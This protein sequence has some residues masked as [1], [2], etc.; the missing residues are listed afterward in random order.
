M[1]NRG[2]ALRRLLQHAAAHRT[3]VR[4]AT[5][6]SV[7]N[8]LFDIAPEVLIGVAVDVVVSRESSFL[9]RLGV[10]DVMMQLFLLGALTLFIWVCES[11]FEYLYSLAWRNLAQSIQHELRVDAYRHIQNL[12]L[13]YFEDKSTGGLLSILNDDVNQLERFLDGGANALI[14]VFTSVVVI[15]AIFFV[16]APKVAA[17]ALIP[18]PFILYGAFRFQALLAPRYANVRDAVGSLGA[19]LANNLTGV[20]TI[21]SYVTE[22]HEIARVSADSEAY[23]MA[24]AEAIRASSAFIPIIRMA[25]LAGFLM[26]LVYGGWLTV[27]GGLAVGSYSVLVFLT[28]R[29]LWPLTGLAQTVDLYERAMAST[30]RVLDLVDTPIHVQGEGRTLPLSQVKGAL[31]FENVSFGYASRA[32]V[33]T[34]LS[35]HIPAGE[36]WAFVGST[37]SGKSTLVK[38]LLRFYTPNAGRILLDG[39]ST[40]EFN[41]RDL[42]RAIGLVSQDVFLIQGTVR[43]NIG[44]GSPSASDAAIQEAAR[45][46]EAHEFIES[47]PQGYDTVV[48]E[49][50]QKLSGGQRQRI[51]IA[52]AVLKAPP[53]LVLDE[54]TSAVDNE[55]ESAI[56]RSLER[57]VLGRTT[58]L[59]AHR[60]STVRNAHRIC[61][62]EKGGIL[63][64]GTHEEL[65]LKGG[66]YAAL[67]KVQTGERV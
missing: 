12:D 35:L 62:L 29:L 39:V 11:L 45:V 20:A 27:N 49:R 1:A 31:T 23:R 34:H 32:N 67:W 28:Q 44:Y 2:S 10:T 30:H 7:M 57:I 24:N 36:T 19:R 40:D 16:I 47:L 60:L 56:Q 53:I 37:G 64:S 65:L 17:F 13:A 3:T 21:K 15:G 26:T 51:S 6:Y 52:R 66:V 42:R 50:G 54:A 5:F 9:A 14:Q 38:L 46:A 41:I 33:L 25:I 22:D 43:E 18:M 4:K 61:V 48:G 8:K 58:I 55:T 59:I 63:E